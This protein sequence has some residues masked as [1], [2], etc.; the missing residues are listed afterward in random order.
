M[1]KR[2]MKTR[3]A[4]FNAVFDL[5]TE[6]ELDKITVL[7]LCECAGIN[8]STF[9]L[10]YKS[11]EDCFQKCFDSFTNKI[12]DLSMDIDYQ[13]TATNPEI[14]VSKVLDVV[15]KNIRY[16]QQFKNSVVY[17]SSIKTLKEKLVASICEK[18]KISVEA[19]YHEYAKI[20]FLVGGCADI[21]LNMLPNLDRQEISRIMIDV[22][23][24]RS[25]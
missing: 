9:Y 15:E 11:I 20:V 5:S 25:E 10:H 17:D 4:V 24:R 12:L 1:D 8:K 2:I 22:I 16:F 3:S 7:E 6:K 14:I 23:R 13:Q 18:N 19:N 21:I